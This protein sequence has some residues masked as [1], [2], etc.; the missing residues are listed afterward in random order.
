M[1]VTKT[2]SAWRL[3]SYSRVMKMENKTKVM[4]VWDDW[5][6]EL[7]DPYDFE[8]PSCPSCGRVG[9][10]VEEDDVLTCKCGEVLR[11]AEEEV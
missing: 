1:K 4:P 7:N 2:E 11:C 3:L 8:Y 5:E 10:V 6:S 9:A